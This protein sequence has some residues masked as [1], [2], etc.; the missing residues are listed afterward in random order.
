MN[1]WHLKLGLC[2]LCGMPCVGTKGFGLPRED[3]DCG[4][5]GGLGVWRAGDCEACIGKERT[6]SISCAVAR[7]R[8]LGEGS[9]QG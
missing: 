9:V 5:Q 6:G 7:G 4:P 1:S 3:E 8:F 2:D